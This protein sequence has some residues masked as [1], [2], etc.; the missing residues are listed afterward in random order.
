ML[1]RNRIKGTSRDIKGHQGTCDVYSAGVQEAMGLTGTD[2]VRNL[3]A[4]LP[5]GH[6]KAMD[7]RP[8]RMA[9]CFLQ[10]FGW[11]DPC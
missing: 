3:S 9:S 2:P 7:A 1:F 5:K 6:P 4:V 11:C 8:S 10:R